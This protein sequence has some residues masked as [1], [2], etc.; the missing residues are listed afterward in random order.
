MID[1]TGMYEL[2]HARFITG[3]NDLPTTREASLPEDAYAYDYTNKCIIKY[4]TPLTLY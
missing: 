4:N 3:P 2:A 1:S